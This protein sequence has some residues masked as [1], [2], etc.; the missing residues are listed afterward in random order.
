MRGRS[1][2]AMACRLPNNFERVKVSQR[3]KKQLGENKRTTA[4]LDERQFLDEAMENNRTNLEGWLKR[5]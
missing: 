1:D 2:A 3:V 5:N 4:D